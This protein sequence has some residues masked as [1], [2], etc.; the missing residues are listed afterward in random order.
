MSR[1]LT[2]AKRVCQVWIDMTNTDTLVTYAELRV[3]AIPEANKT[4]LT[5]AQQPNTSTTAVERREGIRMR[6]SNL[7]ICRFY[8]FD[9]IVHVLHTRL[10]CIISKGPTRSG[11]A[12]FE[13][14]HFICIF[15]HFQ[16]VLIWKGCVC[17]DLAYFLH[18]IHVVTNQKG[19][20][21]GFFAYCLT[22]C[23][24][25]YL[26]RLVLHIFLHIFHSWHI[27]HIR[28][29]VYIMHIL[30]IIHIMHT[31]H[32]LKI[33]C[34]CLG[35]E[36]SYDE[37][38]GTQP[39]STQDLPEEEADAGGSQ[40]RVPLQQL[41]QQQ[42]QPPSMPHP[43]STL[44]KNC[45]LVSSHTICGCTP[46]HLDPWLLCTVNAQEVPSGSDVHKCCTAQYYK[47][48]PQ[49]IL[50]TGEIAARRSLTHKVALIPKASRQVICV[51]DVK[52]STFGT[53]GATTALP[54]NR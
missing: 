41:P 40:S 39:S 52:G 53:S 4:D 6:G 7:Q 5:A 47:W 24:H 1:R 33:D 17:V 3:F 22:Y 26:Y 51:G 37:N 29:I 21:A 16:F 31:L 23:F 45:V 8:I 36:R 38:E 19:V 20:R 28:Q 46:C 42:H 14:V 32:V 9:L 25:L 15:Q 12:P 48:K 11:L 49:L 43:P 2:G 18:I 35:F 50:H 30:H 13:W 44:K 54:L 10:R 27:R 34:F